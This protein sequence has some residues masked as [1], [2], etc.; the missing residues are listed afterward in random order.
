[1]KKTLILVLAVLATFVFSQEKRIE[2]NK[3]LNY[4]FLFKDAKFQHYS[5]KILGSNNSEYLVMARFNEVPVNFFAD[6]LGMS[7][8]SI[9]LNNRLENS[10]FGAMMFGYGL[11]GSNANKGGV[12]VQKL[13]TRE[14]I[15]GFSCNN[16]LLTY[17]KANHFDYGT[18]DTK[19]S[20]DSL[21][22]CVDEKNAVNNISILSGLLNFAGSAKLQTSQLKGLIV[23]VSPGDKSGK[24]AITL[25][26][27]KDTRD[28]VYF[29]HR[30]AMMKQQKM[31][32]SIAL[33]RKKMDDEYNKYSD[34]AYA[35]V[36]SVAAYDDDYFYG[37]E[38]Y[39]STYKNT[40]ED[41]N[42]AISNIPNEKLWDGLPKHCRN[43]EKDVP[44]LDNK[45][46]RAHL[47]NYVGQ[48]CDMYL[49]QS[50]SHNVGIKI[51]LDEIRREVLY[52]NE[53]KE[54]LNKSDQKK[55]NQYLEK[56]D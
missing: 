34:S 25:K 3:E 29:N 18:A 43:F 53:N 12:T 13:N 56:L 21:Y 52:I 4:D 6:N 23:K 44:N 30:D 7:N 54:K 15:A 35:E 10:Y 2:F 41:P 45:E 19:T 26:S 1:M 16:Y 11:F 22:V 31:M 42:Y 20:T 47:T 32:D 39:E 51:T 49:T 17:P 36:D 5:A 50:S 24:E 28:F 55:V 40:P 9:G 14:T 46:F 8:V 38:K 37:V 33:E 27:I 48:M